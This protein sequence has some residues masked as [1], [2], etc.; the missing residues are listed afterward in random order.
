MH[1]DINDLQ[2]KA[3]TKY[4]LQGMMDSTEAKLEEIMD[5][6]MDGLKRE[7]MEGLKNFLIERPPESENVSHEIHDEDTRKMNQYWRN[8]N[9]GLKTNHFPKIDMRKFDGKD[10]ITWILQ[11]EQFFDLHDVPHTQKVQIASLYLEPN[12]FVWYRWLC[13]HKSLVTWKFSWK[14]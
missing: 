2:K 6:N 13:S 12:Q 11:M 3:V 5:T 7:I 9:F 8:S 1:R 4:E 14:K 10:P